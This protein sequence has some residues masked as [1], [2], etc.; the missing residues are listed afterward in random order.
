ML[1][2]SEQQAK[3]YLVSYHFINS[4]PATSIEEIFERIQSIQFDPL[5]VVGINAEL[6]MQSRIRNFKKQDLYNALYRDRILVDGWDKMMG[7]Y[8]SKD[9]PKFKR[10]REARAK[11]EIQLFKN[12]MQI[13]ALDYVDEIRDIIDKRGPLFSTDITMGDSRKQTWGRT[14]PSSAA[15]DYLFHKGDIGVHSRKNTQKKYDLIE[16]L[17]PNGKEPCPFENDEEFI[18]YYL[19]RRIKSMGLVWNKNGVHFYGLHIYSKLTREKHLKR[20]FDQGLIEE[21]S[22]D[23]FTE[24]FYIPSNGLK[25]NVGVLDRISFIA[26][27]D[28]L[29]WD[30]MLLKNLFKFDYSWEVY[31]PVVKRKYGYYVLPI[32]RGSDFIGRIEF[33][34]QRS[35]GPLSIIN[36][37][38]EA[39]INV[40]KTL[41]NKMNSAL[42]RFA[43]YL[44]AKQIIKSKEYEE[45]ERC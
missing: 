45:K 40:N 30:R 8:L 15:I 28:N 34:K 21:V 11:E 20:L 39:N 9:F 7:I 35:D 43:K 25:I 6:V 27:L 4:Q 5:N 13:E 19:L 42:E 38:F 1:N 2:W 12:R 36:V 3:D 14:K 23:G 32:L 22:I 41:V 44:G 16:K 29:I 31:T 37:W 26:P 24:A 10:I 18:D 17:L 33:E